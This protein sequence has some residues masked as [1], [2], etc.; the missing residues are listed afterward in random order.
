MEIS[1]IKRGT[2]VAFPHLKGCERG[3]VVNIYPSRKAV[4]VRWENGK[5]GHVFVGDL[6]PV[7]AE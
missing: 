3:E 1:E 6:R 5:I 4:A 2:V 7:V